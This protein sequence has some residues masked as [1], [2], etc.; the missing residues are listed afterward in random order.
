MKKKRGLRFTTA[1]LLIIDLVLAGYIFYSYL[2]QTGNSLTGFVKNVITRIQSRPSQDTPSGRND[3]I[4]YTVSR[5]ETGRPNM[6][7]FSWYPK[8]VQENTKKYPG[9]TDIGEVTGYWKAY[10]LVD[11]SNKTANAVEFLLNFDISVT[12]NGVEGTFVWYSY[13][14]LNSP[15]TI[16]DDTPAT[17][18][19]GKF[20]N[21]SN[22]LELELAGNGKLH[23]QRFYYY[24]DREYGIG[25][26]ETATGV[27][28]IICLVRP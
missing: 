24:N 17:T 20:I 9:I 3:K 1:L 7:D 25:T 12:Q 4:D 10:I 19:T 8:Q 28:A 11:P 5:D 2:D 26:M 18:Y 6:D 15:D 23:I 13:H 14:Y 16:Y 27:D 22:G 21:G